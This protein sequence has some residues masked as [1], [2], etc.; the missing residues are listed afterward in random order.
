[1]TI[2]TNNTSSNNKTNRYLIS[3][4]AGVTAGLIAGVTTDRIINRN[5]NNPQNTDVTRRTATTGNKN[6]ILKIP[7]R[8]RILSNTGVYSEANILALTAWGV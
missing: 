4:S 1:M 7:Y 5:N 2:N 8:K 6:Y 3:A